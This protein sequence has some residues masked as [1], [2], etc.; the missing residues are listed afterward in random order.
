MCFNSMWIESPPPALATWPDP[1][2]LPLVRRAAQGDKAGHLFR[3]SW[4][5]LAFPRAR[6]G[7]MERFPAGFRTNHPTAPFCDQSSPAAGSR[8]SARDHRFSPGQPASCCRLPARPRRATHGLPAGPERAPQ[9]LPPGTNSGPRDGP[10]REYPPRRHCG[11]EV[12]QPAIHRLSPGLSSEKG[13]AVRLKP[14]AGRG[15]GL[16]THPFEDSTRSTAATGPAGRQT[17]GVP[18]RAPQACRWRARR[19]CHPWIVT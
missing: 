15:R 12:G 14:T 8:P 10:V 6:D 2:R 17:A 3:D 13:R 11:E 4:P 18:A 7:S 16:V 5:L 9:D 1:P 19:A